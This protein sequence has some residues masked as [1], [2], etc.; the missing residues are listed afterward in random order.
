MQDKSAN[1]HRCASCGCSLE[2]AKAVELCL[3]CLVAQARR[4]MGATSP[5]FV[6]GV[7]SA[8]KQTSTD[9]GQTSIKPQSTKQA[10]NPQARPPATSKK[11]G[12]RKQKN[13]QIGGTQKRRQTKGTTCLLCGKKIAPGML[14]AHKQAVHGEPSY[15]EPARATKKPKSIWISIVS[16]GLPGL[17]KKK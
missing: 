14:L 13:K 9:F 11:T 16:G 4:N 2:G 1:V 15:S 17:G 7:D 8:K 12:K 5:L 6:R 3:P 10:T